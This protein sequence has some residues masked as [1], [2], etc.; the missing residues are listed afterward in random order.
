MYQGKQPCAGCGRPGSQIARWSKD[1]LCPEC[2][3]LL[4]KGKVLSLEP[5]EYCRVNLTWYSFYHHPLNNLVNDFMNAISLPEAK[6]LNAPMG[7]IYLGHID[8]VT[9]SSR[10]FVPKFVADALKNLIEGIQQE[11]RMLANKE[12]EIPKMAKEEVAKEK[13]KYFEEGLMRGRNML[14]QLNRGEITLD[15]FEAIPKPYYREEK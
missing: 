7:I 3:D 1:A 8:A 12:A 2:A 11:G 5:R 4:Q 14:A 10:Y 9:A 6:H 13:Q 15:Q